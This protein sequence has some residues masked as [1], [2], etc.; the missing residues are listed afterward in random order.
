ME[1]S[2]SATVAVRTVKDPATQRR[3]GSFL[4]LRCLFRRFALKSARLAALFNEKTVKDKLMS[5]PS[6]TGVEKD[7]VE[8]LN[9]D[10][11]DDT[12][13]HTCDGPVQD[14]HRRVSLLIKRDIMQQQESDTH[15]QLDPAQEK[16][17]MP[18]RS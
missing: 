12:S 18:N 13:T 1:L 4:G 15:V 2:G 6:L 14:R 10:E 8:N 9:V 16:S 11:L 17:P 3:L 7:A 5:F